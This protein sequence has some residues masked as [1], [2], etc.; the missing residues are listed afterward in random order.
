MEVEQR[1]NVVIVDVKQVFYHE[2]GQ[3]K[4]VKYPHS[5]QL[6][7]RF[8]WLLYLVV[9]SLEKFNQFFYKCYRQL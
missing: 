5:E 1:F 6:Q 2:A 4:Y 3:G 7:H 8:V 9:T